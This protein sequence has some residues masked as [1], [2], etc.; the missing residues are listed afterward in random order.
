MGLSMSR[1]NKD[2]ISWS[3]FRLHFSIVCDESRLRHYTVV[4]VFTVVMNRDVGSIAKV[5]G[6]WIEGNS[7]FR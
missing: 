7:F 5:G 1:R 4:M 3:N 2:R 6:T